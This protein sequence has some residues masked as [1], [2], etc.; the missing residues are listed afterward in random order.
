QTFRPPAE[1]AIGTIF[2][3]EAPRCTMLPVLRAR[4]AHAFSIEPLVYGRAPVVLATRHTGARPRIDAT[5]VDA[6]VGW[7]AASTGRLL[8]RAV[9]HDVHL[10]SRHGPS[11]H[12]HGRDPRQR[13]SLHGATTRPHRSVVARASTGKQDRSSPHS[14]EL[15][16]GTCTKHVGS[17]QR[18]R[19]AERN[20]SA[21]QC[22][23]SRQRPTPKPMPP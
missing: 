17:L 16:Q 3:P 2:V 20:S 23:S 5:P 14:A 11:D 19:H 6:H 8:F 7:I 12:A 4:V 15:R 18:S 1:Q 13:D 22:R 10:T 9:I 21:P